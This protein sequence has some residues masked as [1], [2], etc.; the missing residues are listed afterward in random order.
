MISSPVN[1]TLSKDF[2]HL[3]EELEGFVQ[4]TRDKKY[5]QEGL[6]LKVLQFPQYETISFASL[7]IYTHAFIKTDKTLYFE[8]C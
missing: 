7:N 3:E 6:Q 8:I 2:S 4:Q 1:K 5:I